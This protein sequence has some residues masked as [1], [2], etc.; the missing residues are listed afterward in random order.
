MATLP[1]IIDLQICGY[2]YVVIIKLSAM[3]LVKVED[4]PE[5]CPECGG[6]VVPIV[7]GEP[8]YETLLESEKG[9]VVLYGCCIFLDGEDL[10]SPDWECI[11]CHTCFVKTENSYG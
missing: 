6:R 10:V 3:K 7:Y 8:T 2:I 9:N 4:R 1:N 11:E 5:K